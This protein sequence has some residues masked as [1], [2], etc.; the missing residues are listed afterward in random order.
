[1]DATTFLLGVLVIAAIARMLQAEWHHRDLLRLLNDW[2][3]MT[4]EIFPFLRRLV[5]DD[6]GGDHDD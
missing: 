4:G 3:T 5:G 6:K 2:A 1:M